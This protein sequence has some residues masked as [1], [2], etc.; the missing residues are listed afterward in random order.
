MLLCSEGEKAFSP[1]QRVRQT[2]RIRYGRFTKAVFPCVRAFIV[3]EYRLPVKTGL[4]RFMK[5]FAAA[6]GRQQSSQ[7]R[8]AL[9]ESLRFYEEGAA[10]SGYA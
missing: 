7:G 5:S 2:G 8:A 9:R 10:A 3:V 1:A 4:G 6:V